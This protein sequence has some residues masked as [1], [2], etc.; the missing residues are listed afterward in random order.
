MTYDQFILDHLG[1]PW[2]VVDPNAYAQ[3][4]DL[5]VGYC[6]AL[7]IPR[8]FQFENAYEIYT[9]FGAE[10]AKYFDR[11]ENTPTAV[12]PEGAIVVFKSSYNNGPGHVCLSM[13]YADLDTFV[14]F[15]QNDPKYN[16]CLVT[17]YN[18]NKVHGW[19]IP[20]NKL[21]SS[22]INSNSTSTSPEIAKWTTYTSALNAHKD[23]VD[24]SYYTDD[25]KRIVDDIVK[26]RNSNQVLTDNN[27]QL[28]K[29]LSAI[30][31]AHAMELEEKEKEFK[32][33]LSNLDRELLKETKRANSAEKALKDHVCP[34]WYEGLLQAV[35]DVKDY[36]KNK[37]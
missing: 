17:S 35:E 13:K 37:K 33:N 10:Q 36:L 26:Y 25:P 4:F 18:Y 14:A 11:V 5:A 7:G 30:V 1:E 20:K 28:T 31:K 3:C 12:P 24:V 19:L 32:R 29:N 27:G 8:V 22:T 9:R 16:T 23:N 34:T 21:S 15:S 6:D 2:E